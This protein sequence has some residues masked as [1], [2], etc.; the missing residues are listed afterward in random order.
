MTEMCRGREEAAESVRCAPVTDLLFQI[1]HEIGFGRFECRTELKR[2][3]ATQAEQKREP[4]STAAF[5][6]KIDN[7]GKVYAAEQRCERV[8]AGD[9]APTLRMRPTTP[10]QNREQQS[11]QSSCL[12]I[13]QRDAPTPHSRTAIS[14]DRRCPA[15]SSILARF[16]PRSAIRAPASH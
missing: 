10:P 14:L 2:T 9:V 15:A 8:K 1:I 4:E 6:R 13:R 7:E 16:K 3:V 11:S 5:R 12:T